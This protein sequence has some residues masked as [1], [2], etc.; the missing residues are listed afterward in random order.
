MK[1]HNALTKEILDSSIALMKLVTYFCIRK[2]LKL[3]TNESDFLIEEMEKI[4]HE[5]N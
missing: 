1:Y 4:S 2:P 5:E 3:V